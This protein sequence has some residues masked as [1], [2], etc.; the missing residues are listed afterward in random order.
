MVQNRIKQ[1]HYSKC[2]MLTEG[3]DGKWRSIPPLKPDGFDAPYSLWTRR[4]WLRWSHQRG[5]IMALVCESEFC[6]KR[7]RGGFGW[8]GHMK[9]VWSWHWVCKSKFCDKYERGGFG[10]NGHLKEVRSSWH[11]QWLCES[12][13]SNK[14]LATW[15]IRF[16]KKLCTYLDVCDL[17]LIFSAHPTWTT[18]AKRKR[19][20]NLK[21][22]NQLIWFCFLR[23][24]LS[25][26]LR[27]DCYRV[28][29]M[30]PPGILARRTSVWHATGTTWSTL[31]LNMVGTMCSSIRISW[32]NKMHKD[33]FYQTFA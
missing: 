8:N 1:T 19:T 22:T 5:K 16:Q 12:E 32:I 20:S 21:K 17:I 7:E 6:D 26:Q 23:I 10:W 2:S 15:S 18:L 13:L 11:C 25:D 14:C 24:K 27:S 30:H 4:V 3:R 28:L 29:L 33:W 31:G 9:G